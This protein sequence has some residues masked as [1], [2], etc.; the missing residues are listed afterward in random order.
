MLVATV[1]QLEMVAIPGSYLG[2]FHSM[3]FQSITIPIQSG[4]SFYFISDGLYDV[5]PRDVVAS[6][7]NFDDT[8]QTLNQLALKK[9]N[10]DDCSAVCIHIGSI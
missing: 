9:G 1:Q 3:E 10:R 6:A 2:I 8:L 5:I 7:R 4:D